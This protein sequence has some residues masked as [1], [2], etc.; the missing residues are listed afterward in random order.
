MRPAR[1]SH[2]EWGYLAP[3]PSF[4]RTVRIVVT[5]VA[6]GA[7]AGAATAV[8]L[9]DRSGADE[10]VAARTLAQPINEAAAPAAPAPQSPVA[11][12]A[13]DSAPAESSTAALA[14]HSANAVALAESP[15]IN[16]PG[17]AADAATTYAVPSQIKTTKKPQD[18]K[19][20]APLALLPFFRD[21]ATAG[22]NWPYDRRSDYYD[23]RSD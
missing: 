16:A 13:A 2:P 11:S 7:C 10:S 19:R 12:Q 14:P 18:T 5:A 8:S 15:R 1:Y 3:A 4:M 6:V 20:G 22:A 9:I 17:P 21:R 23:R